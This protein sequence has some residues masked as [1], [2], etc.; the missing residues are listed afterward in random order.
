MYTDIF[1]R[2]TGRV[3]LA[4]GLLLVGLANEA[5]AVDGVVLIDQAKAMAGNVTPYDTPGFPVT[6][7]QVGSY[8]LASNLIVPDAN[9]T[10]IDAQVW[11]VFL[12]LNGFTIFGPTTCSATAVCSP[13]GSGMGV[14]NVQSVVNGSVIGMGSTGISIASI[15]GASIERVVV[16]GNGG[17]G[18][19]CTT[20]CVVNRVRAEYNK[21]DGIQIR[22][23][24]VSDSTSQ[25]NG[26]SGIAV[27]DNGT[28]VN[29]VVNGNNT[30]PSAIGDGIYLNR[31][32]V[33]GCTAVGNKHYGI[34]IG[35]GGYVNNALI[36]N[37]GTGPQ[38]WGGLQMGGNVCGNALCP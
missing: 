21:R 19:L 8:R 30:D 16:V 33:I 34:R 3:L 11:P 37:N 5:R 31:G 12:D 7:S 35:A 9:T 27:L 14:K 28:V 17:V 38:T 29:S 20:N 15:S 24:V 23:G 10:A 6:I 36:N 26:V 13:L 22:S 4:T 18:V 25:N 1:T 2:N 32:T